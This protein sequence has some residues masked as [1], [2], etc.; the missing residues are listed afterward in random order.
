MAGSNRPSP[1]VHATAPH[2]SCIDARTPRLRQVHARSQ[3][4]HFRFRLFGGYPRLNRATCG[5]EWLNG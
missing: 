1:S 4:Q 5:Q 3:R 2:V